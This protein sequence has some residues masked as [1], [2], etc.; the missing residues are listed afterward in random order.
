M[1]ICCSPPFERLVVG[2]VIVGVLT[3]DAVLVATSQNVEQSSLATTRGSHDGQRLTRQHRPCDAMKDFFLDFRLPLELE[4]V[5]G[6]PVCIGL[7][8]HGVAQVD[9]LHHHAVDINRQLCMKPFPS[10]S[11]QIQKRRKRSINGC[12]VGTLT[13]IGN[14]T[15]GSLCRLLV[16]VSISTVKSEVGFSVAAL[17]TALRL[18]ARVIAGGNLPPA[19][20]FSGALRSA[21]R[22]PR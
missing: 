19:A 16:W 1:I 5:L 22:A 10:N 11:S 7:D 15:L 3:R 21:S 2:N 18:I 17:L 4:R 9:K 8:L 6:A 20:E 13:M 12:V 14:G